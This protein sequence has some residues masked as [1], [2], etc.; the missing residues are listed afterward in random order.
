MEV[1]REY[2]E[3]E[4]LVSD[5]FDTMYASEGVGLA[6]PQIGKSLR[7]FV[8]DTSPFGQYDPSAAGYKRVFVNPEITEESDEEL[9]LIHI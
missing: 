6:A 9:S 4:K 2:P 5:M 3:L 1:E 7:L 8:V